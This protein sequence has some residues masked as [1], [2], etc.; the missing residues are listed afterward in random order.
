MRSQAASYASQVDVAFW[1]IFIVSTILLTGI[2]LFMIFCLYRYSKKRNPTP[3]TFD[4]S[5]FLETLWTVIPTI[6]VMIMF[7]LGYEGFLSMRQ[8]PADSMIIKVYARMWN[9]RFEYPDGRKTDKLVVPLNKPV[10]LLMYSEDVIHSFY[11]P[12]FRNKEDVVPGRENFL[13]FKAIEEGTFDVL[14]AEY[15]G[16]LHSY[17]STTIEVLKQ[18]EYEAWEKGIVLE[19]KGEALKGKE[20]FHGKGACMACHSVDGSKILGPTLKGLWNSKTIVIQ[21]GKERE[22]VANEDYIK[23]AILNPSK[24]C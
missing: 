11:I 23:E 1:F 3:A 6:L 18:E 20:I 2:T 9:W 15:C 22:V 21:D 17:M 24:A 8:A 4:G 10:K 7:Y 14:C 12:A 19:I 5:I 16:D 13:W